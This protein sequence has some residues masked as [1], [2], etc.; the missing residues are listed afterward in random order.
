MVNIHW[1]HVFW[2]KE[3]KQVSNILFHLREFYFN[4]GQENTYYSSWE[5]IK[6]LFIGFVYFV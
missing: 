4:S 3:S 6:L 1:V 2:Q 5:K